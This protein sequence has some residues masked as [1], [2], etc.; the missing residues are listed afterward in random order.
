MLKNDVPQETP[1]R[2]TDFNFRNDVLHE[3]LHNLPIGDSRGGWL[4]GQGF[5][6]CQSRF[7]IHKPSQLDLAFKIGFA[8]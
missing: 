2:D 5:N 6:R 8:A 7:K 4:L 3:D 1:E